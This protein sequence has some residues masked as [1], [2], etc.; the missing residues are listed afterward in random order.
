MIGM[1]MLWFDSVFDHK[2]QAN[3]CM[4]HDSWWVSVV[5]E[6]PNSFCF[7]IWNSIFNNQT[8]SLCSECIQKLSQWRSDAFE[9]WDKIN[10]WHNYICK[11]VLWFVDF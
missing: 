5:L 8:H 2:K 7:W 1:L 10:I 3:K 9:K 4:L 6:D 11:T